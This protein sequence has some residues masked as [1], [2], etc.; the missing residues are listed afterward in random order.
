VP[1]NNE[2]SQRWIEE[3]GR[4]T[5]K[6]DPADLSSIY[7][8]IIQ[9]IQKIVKKIFGSDIHI[10]SPEPKTLLIVTTVIMSVMLILFTVFLFRRFG[11]PLGNLFTRLTHPEKK[12]VRREYDGLLIANDFTAAM[13]FIV[14]YISDTKSFLGR[15]FSEL[16]HIRNSDPMLRLKAS[17]G[18][19]MHRGDPVTKEDL[20]IFESCA[21]KVYPEFESLLKKNQRRK[22][23]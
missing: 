15:T 3:I 13:R 21:S 20:E 16:F 14:R 22:K 5:P 8:A 11:S 10:P 2:L 12:Q 18:Q 19:T 6:P 4:I 9:W 23:G 1:Q 17:Y 7:Q